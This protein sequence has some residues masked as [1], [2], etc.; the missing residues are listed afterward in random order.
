LGI[1]GNADDP[2]GLVFTNA[3][4]R[5]INAAAKPK[6]PPVLTP[7][8]NWRHPSGESLD[9]AAVYFNARRKAS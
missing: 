4:G 9:Y 2:D 3:R 8:G 6:P 7:A 5:V 1:S